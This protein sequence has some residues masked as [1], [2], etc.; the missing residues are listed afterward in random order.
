MKK[1]LFAVAIIA[2]TQLAVAQNTN[3]LANKIAQA[4]GLNNFSKASNLSFTFNVSRENNTTSRSWYWDITTNTVT[5]KTAKEAVTYKRDTITTA[6]MKSVDQR[7]I[8]DQYW[9]LF[10]YHLVWDAGT[11]I[12][13]KENVEAPISKKMMTMLTI[14]YNNVDGYTPGD[15]YDLFV[16]ANNVVTEWNFRK[17]GA[18][19]P[20]LST[21]WMDN[22]TFKGI[23][24]P[25]DHTTADE[26]FRLFFTDVSVN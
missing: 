2:I 5:M 6:A 25:M 19:T 18:A 24:I 20:S 26:K 1:I 9:L 11:T 22:K 10:P 12:T 7:F 13:T 23:V 3:E 16:D 21:T 8:N 4:Y 14:Q 15:A 17:G